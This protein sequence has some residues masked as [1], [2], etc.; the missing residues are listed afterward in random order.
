[1]GLPKDFVVTVFIVKKDNILLVKH[2]ELGLWLPIGGHID[3]GEHP[4]EA[5]EREIKEEC[6]LE[7]DLIA[8]RHPEVEWEEVKAMPIPM[9]LQVE[10]ID[11]KHE[12]VD[13]IYAAKYLSGE[14]TLADKEHQEIRWFSLKEIENHKK[15]DIGKDVKFLAGKSVEIVKNSEKK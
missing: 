10:Y 11:G 5:L 8:E 7:V 6:G 14:P 1:M 12:H 3:G 9:Q 13:F 15:R 2:R 4:E